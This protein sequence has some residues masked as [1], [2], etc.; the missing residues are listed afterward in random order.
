MLD[1]DPSLWTQIPAWVLT[2][3]VLAKIVGWLF[4][5]LAPNGVKAWWAEVVRSRQHDDEIEEARVHAEL[6][7]AATLQLQKKYTDDMLF[8]LLASNLEWQK[9]LFKELNGSFKALTAE[10]RNIHLTN[11]RQNDLLTTTNI[12]IAELV[13]LAKHKKANGVARGAE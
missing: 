12:N 2:V 13:D 8:D 1:I 7:N 6:N 4:P 9:E 3:F 10:L 11:Q 5:I